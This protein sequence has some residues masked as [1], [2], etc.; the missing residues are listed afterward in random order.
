MTPDNPDPRIGSADLVDDSSSE[1]SAAYTIGSNTTIS[2]EPMEFGRY[3]VRGVRGTGGFGTVYAGYDSHLE[4]EVA[5]KVPFATVKAADL[6]VFM[7]EARN[8]A[9]LRHPGILTVFD[10]GVEDGQCFIVSD[11]LDGAPL[12]RVVEG[13]RRRPGGR[14]RRSSPASPRRW[15]TPTSARSSIAT[16]SPGNVILTRDRGPVLVDFGLAITD[17]ARSSELGVRSGTPS[18][19]SPEQIEGKAH[20]IDGRTDIYSLGVTLYRMICGRLPFRARCSSKSWCARFATTNRSRR[21]SSCP[22]CRRNW[23]ASASPRWP[24]PAADRY[25][26]AGD[27]ARE[28]R[29]LLQGNV[30][31]RRQERR[32]EAPRVSAPAARVQRR[33]LSFLAVSWEAPRRTKTSTS[34]IRPRLDA[35]FKQRCTAIVDAVRRHDPPGR[36]ATRSSLLRV[37]GRA[38]EDAA[39]RAVYAAIDIRELLRRDGVRKR[40]ARAGYSVHTGTVVVRQSD[41]DKLEVS[42]DPLTV[43]RAPR[44]GDRPGRGLPDPRHVALVSG[45]FDVEDAGSRPRARRARADRTCSAS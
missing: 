2:R 30:A 3:Q 24:R 45:H 42:G 15:P 20:R 7:R 33:H 9:R 43:V 28:L 18:F 39:R 41:D 26:T 36:A 6:D 32:A 1:L 34:T 35:T 5:I 38:Q 25:T 23:S 16:S 19:M 13:T 12:Q 29:D 4:R 10:V 22:T 37:S 21:G 14:R 27:M 8:L 31:A 17:Q 11:L 40:A 44:V